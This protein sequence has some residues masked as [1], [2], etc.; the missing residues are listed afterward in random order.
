[1]LIVYVNIL[2]T[3]A[4][5][6]HKRTCMFWGWENIIILCLNLFN[7]FTGFVL[8]FSLY[9]WESLAET[10]LDIKLLPV[11]IFT[12]A[13]N[14]SIIL[15]LVYFSIFSITQRTGMLR[16]IYD[17]RCNSAKRRKL[18]ALALFLS[19]CF[20]FNILVILSGT[21]KTPMDNLIT[22]LN[23]AYF[24][25]AFPL[26]LVFAVWKFMAYLSER[27]EKI[28]KGIFKLTVFVLLPLYSC[29]V[30]YFVLEL[31]KDLYYYSIIF[32]V[33]ICLVVMLS[34]IPLLID[35]K[36]SK[37]I[38]CI[39][40]KILWIIPAWFLGVYWV[41]FNVQEDWIVFITLYL[42]VMLGLIFLLS[43]PIMKLKAKNI[44]LRREVEEMCINQNNG[45][46]I[47][48]K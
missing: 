22:L 31:I 8:I 41:C 39:M 1:M 10:V 42:S 14:F 15:A 33:L 19:P 2:S 25:M 35:E 44:E 43:S 40:S 6:T 3:G 48:N 5:M 26:I 34:G 16:Y 32:E 24:S 4:I 7:C 36:T 12:A 37:L 29:L 11:Y 20:L 38:D 47:N 21:F 17:L 23:G 13:L 30:H 28:L 27:C 9:F 46:C 18:Y 45:V